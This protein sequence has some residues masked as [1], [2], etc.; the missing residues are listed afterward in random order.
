MKLLFA[1]GGTAGHINPA[2]A[3]AS[4]IKE[5]HP[6]YEIMFIGTAEH[7]ESRLVPNAGFDFKTIEINGFKR[8]FSPKAII[9]N[10]KTVVKLIKSEKE[11]KNII[12]AFQPDVVIGF[13]GYVSG[14]VLDEAVKLHIP[15]CIHEQNAFP[16]ITNKQLAKKVDKV[17]LTVEDAAN[18]MEAKCDVVITGLPV[19]GELL[20]KSKFEARIELGIADDKPLVLSFGGSLGAAP[21]NE[22]MFDIILEDAEKNDVYHIHSVGTN[23][24]EYLEK[25]EANGFTKRAENIYYKGNSEV[26][27]YIDNM[28]TCMAAADLVIGRAGASSLSEIEA[29]GKASILIPSPYVAENHQFH[30][31]MAL[32]NRN[33]A[34]ILREKDLNSASLKTLIDELLSDKAELAEIEKNAKDMAILDSRERIADIILSLAK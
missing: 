28:D 2:L 33:A 19:R 31:A 24:K 12:T 14:P 9:E 10:V 27:L 25:F 5:Q 26:R 3:V 1:T 13:G 20:K 17:M 4:Y 32:V 21:L 15:T 7:M 22:A 23:G 6:D 18:H 8:S 30:N 29:M 16:G 11:S 34:R